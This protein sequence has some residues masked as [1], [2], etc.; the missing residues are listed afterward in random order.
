[1]LQLEK[2]INFGYEMLDLLLMEIRRTHEAYMHVYE[3]DKQI[4]LG[5][6]KGTQIFEWENDTC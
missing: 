1:M 3:E 4:L 6:K 2:V 5:E